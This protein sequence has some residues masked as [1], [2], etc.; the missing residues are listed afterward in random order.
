[1]Y[2]VEHNELQEAIRGD[3]PT[4]NDGDFMAQSTMMAI[5]G[6]E[7]AYTGQKVS[8]NDALNATTVLGP[9]EYAFADFEL[10]AVAQPGATKLNR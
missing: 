9:K 7:A 8:F 10:P 5:M 2:Q 3:R 1:M 6:R 4:V